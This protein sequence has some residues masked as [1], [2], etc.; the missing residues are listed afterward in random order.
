MTAS[1]GSKVSVKKS[2]ARPKIRKILIASGVNLDLLGVREPDIYGRETLKDMERLV[3]SNLRQQYGSESTAGIK[4]VFFQTNDESKLLGEIGK[5][6]AGIV[7]NAG[8]WTHT[9]LAL[10]D[11]LVGLNVPYAEAHVSDL[12]TRES[13]RHHSFLS[14]HAVCV[15]QGLGIKSYWVALEALLS[16]SP[17]D[18]SKRRDVPR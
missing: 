11:R 9:S 8:A 10:S 14:S 16:Q 13:F 4:L 12:T 2:K 3:R 5:G 6:Y 18:L 1:I 17:F 7:I 15:V